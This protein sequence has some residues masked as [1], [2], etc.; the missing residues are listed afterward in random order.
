MSSLKEEQKK[1]IRPEGVGSSGE[2]DN[3]DTHPERR[4][5]EVDDLENLY[6]QESRADEDRNTKPDSASQTEQDELPSSADEPDTTDDEGSGWDNKVKG[7]KKNKFSGKRMAIGGSSIG[8]IAGL[9]IGFS[10]FISGPLQFIHFAQLLQQFHFGSSERFGNSRTAKIFRWAT[11]RNPRAQDFNLSR[12]GNKLAVH[13]ENKLKMNGVELEYNGRAG[14]LSGL[15]IDPNSP[16]GKK[17]LSSIAA[18]HGVELRP[19]PGESKIKIALAEDSSEIVSAGTRR[20]VVRTLVDTIEMNGISS[21]M[22]KRL[23]KI[24]AGVSFHPL[25]NIARSV[26]EKVGLKYQEWKEKIKKDRADSIKNGSEEPDLKAKA[27]A[28]DPE[29]PPTEQEKQKIAQTDG[30]MDDLIETARDPDIPATERTPLIKSKIAKGGV[31]ALA[32]IGLLCG[33]D[34]IGEA[35]GKLQEDNIIKPLIRVATTGVITPAA[36][37]MSG[38]GIS[39]DELGVLAESFYNKED[40]TSWVSAEGIQYNLGNP[41]TGVKIPDNAKPGKD[42]PAFFQIIHNIVSVPVMKQTCEAL[43]ST[44]GMIALTLGNLAVSV[45]GVGTLVLQVGGEVVTQVVTNTFMDDFI[46]W[47][48]GDVVD[49]TN[50]SGGKFGALADTGAFLADNNTSLALGGRVLTKNE[51]IALVNEN[52]EDIR[53]QN[54]QKPYYARLFDLKNPD[55]LASEITTQGYSLQNYQKTFASLIGNPLTLFKSI[56]SDILMLNPKAIAQSIPFDYGVDK[57]GF[58]IEERESESVENP[59]ENEEHIRPLLGDLNKKYGEVCFGAKVDPDSGKF[60][61]TQAPSYKDLEENK[62]VCGN[63]NK[64]PDFL[65]YRMYLAD[66]VTMAAATC[67]NSIDETACAD[68]DIGNAKGAQNNEN[69]GGAV[70]PNNPAK[71]VDTS[72]QQCTAGNDLGVKDSPTN[73]IKIRICNVGGIDVNVAIENNVRTMLADAR[74][75]G[76]NLG[77]GGFR[78]YQEQI[79]VRKNNC[80]TSDYDIYQKPASQCRPATAIPGN[81]MHEWGLALDI[82][83]GGSTIKSGSAA[84]NWLQAN[85]S[86]YGLKNLPSEAWHW[87]TTGT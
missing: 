47:L 23:L 72:A 64:D 76:I 12:G 71:G 79:S 52:Q 29:D 51:Q 87:S 53:N 30:E 34:K 15:S 57:I 80:G 73:G 60:I 35:A 78:S 37:I 11:S 45:T 50:I 33:L 27:R 39:M 2:H 25:K 36:Q 84:F 54:K 31:G 62:A 61:Y 70:N 69:D 6:N 85:A 65:K 24:R 32:V 28:E 67:Y 77:G 41:N 59:Y 17:F 42:R 22:A 43:S 9:G 63:E 68:L 14:R 81:S 86:K 74:A 1:A 7:K 58:S 82:M 26:D 10:V 19:N 75:A 49:I 38:Q 4:E 56:S 3:L 21:A 8:I 83:V 18:E 55:S 16:S 20:R 13:Y 46:A 5:A 40:G 66:S 44:V 48:A